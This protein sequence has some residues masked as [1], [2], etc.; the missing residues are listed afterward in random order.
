MVLLLASLFLAVL[1]LIITF[2]VVPSWLY[3][4]LLTGTALYSGAIIGVWRGYRVAY[5]MIGVLATTI[6]YVSLR[7]PAH[8]EFIRN[9]M[10]LE[11][12]IF[13]TG[14]ILQILILSIL[15]MKLFRYILQHRQ[16]S[17]H[18]RQPP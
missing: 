4:S 2:G 18:Q 6:L 1:L 17:Q 14:T 3:Y 5:F 13:I 11:A 12:S 16:L 15:L 9:Q 10:F 7:S 8:Y